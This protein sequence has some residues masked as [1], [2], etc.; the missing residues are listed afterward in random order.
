[1]DLVNFTQLAYLNSAAVMSDSRVVDTVDWGYLMTPSAKDRWLNA[2]ARC[3]LSPRRFAEIRD[4]ANAFDRWGI[5]FNWHHWPDSHPDLLNF[6]LKDLGLVRIADGDFLTKA[7]E[8]NSASTPGS[9]DIVALDESNF[10]SYIRAKMLGWNN[11]PQQKTEIEIAARHL[12][13]DPR[14]QTWVLVQ[15][16]EVVGAASSHNDGKAAYLRG[17]FVVPDLRGKGFYRRLIE[18]RERALL[19][20]GVHSLTVI[21]DRETSAPIY[22]KMNYAIQGEVHVLARKKTQWVSL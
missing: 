18:F 19:A 15:N 17:D 12:M 11:G 13:K 21:A 20:K 9:K 14:N 1:V 8:Q 16:G 5:N 7:I 10:D 6:L 22:K 4:L 2:V 3:R